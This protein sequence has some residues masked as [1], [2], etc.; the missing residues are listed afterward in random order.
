MPSYIISEMNTKDLKIEKIISLP[1]PFRLVKSENTGNGIK[2]TIIE[3]I[4]MKFVF[5][6]QPILT[7][8]TIEIFI[9]RNGLMLSSPRGVGVVKKGNLRKY[10]DNIIGP[11]L[12]KELTG[13]YENYKP[14]LLN[15][16][17]MQ[18]T[19]WG[20]DLR[21][22]RFEIP[23]IGTLELR[24]RKLSDTINRNKNLKRLENAG[25]TI[26]FKVFN[27]KLKRTIEISRE[28]ILKTKFN[29]IE[30]IYMFVSEM[31]K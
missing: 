6:D 9:G 4:K 1:E 24:G 30:D 31:I 23:E 15:N 27:S 10:I 17:I 19:K 5:F 3:P 7:N 16:K 25:E 21:K 2:L 28:G 14:K 20:E 13:K 29:Q 12:A 26:S 22:I 8:I 18:P 11:L